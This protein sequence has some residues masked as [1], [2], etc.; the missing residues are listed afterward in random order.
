MS[1]PE[2]GDV[3]GPTAARPIVSAPFYGSELNESGPGSAHVACRCINKVRLESSRGQMRT[4][5]H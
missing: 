1:R 5:S 3:C 2:G 4:V